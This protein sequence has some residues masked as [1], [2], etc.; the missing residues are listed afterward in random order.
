MRSTARARLSVQDTLLT[1]PQMPRPSDS[2]APTVADLLGPEGVA[3]RIVPGW[4]ARES[5]LRLAE[6]IHER[7]V[8]GGQIVVEAPT[9]V[10]KTLGYLVPAV[11]SGKR[12][13][14]STNTKTLQDQ[15]VQRDLPALATM[16][17]A[18]G[19]TL[20]RASPDGAP[21]EQEDVVRYALMKGRSNYLCIDRL[22]KKRRQRAFDFE[23]DTLW[24]IEQWA[25]E[26][27][28]GDRAELLGLSDK[29]PLWG[30]IDARSEVCSGARCDAY[31]SCFVTRMR[32]E[33]S[34]AS[35]VI[36]NHHLLMADIALKAQ[37][38]LSAS[39]RSFGAVIPECDALIVDEAHA[40]EEIASDHFGGQVSTRKLERLG[41]DLYAF[42][43]AAPRRDEGLL[44]VQISR[45]LET[46]E[47]VFARLPRQEGRVRLASANV[48]AQLAGAKDSLP[49]AEAALVGL[50]D[51]FE[52]EA[53][54]DSTAESLARRAR[55]VLDSL[56]FVLSAEDADFVY[57]AERGP[58]HAALGASPVDVSNLLGRFMFDTFESVA[59]TS[60]TLSAGEADAG[61]FR[62]AVGLGEDAQ[63]LI[64][65][66]PFDFPA[67]AALYLPEDA[68]DP[69]AP[70]APQRLA[71]I[72]EALIRAVGGGAMYLFTSYRSMHAV[73]R[74][75]QSR[76]PYPVLMQGEAP[77]AALLE[78]MVSQAPAVLFATASFWEGV[79]IPGDPLR[80]VMI[81]KLPFDPPSDPLI[82]ARSEAMEASGKSAFNGLLVPRAILRLEQGFGRLIRSRRDRGVVAILDRRIQS[83]GYGKRFVR[84]LP[85]A[86]LIREL[87]GLEA[88]WAGSDIAHL[89]AK[90][91]PAARETSV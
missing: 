56:R 47:S 38:S 55:E 6:A 12:V 29:S 49:D 27:L 8:Q 44:R 50:V 7:I 57:W 45:A 3:A 36:V 18:M 84:A 63:V 24:E 54:E 14:V 26:T 17:Q 25:K 15:I 28:R 74:L 81:D 16:M 72:G 69:K 9:G 89:G 53:L 86:T 82:A 65:D 70:D 88:W 62:R 58:K 78:A 5:Q 90:S 20:E 31:E 35:I 68:P 52:R 39:G 10:G 46:T 40:L 4:E 77:K 61:F 30:E 33:A 11:L 41:R 80:L 19:L 48:G 73:H 76:L 71:D 1:W 42:L 37:A 43:E 83:R 32:Q 13:V 51:S 79:D 34:R 22:R 64:L 67:Q 59:L 2:P 66:S 91:A 75:L 23:T 60:A 85:D 21:D 87:G